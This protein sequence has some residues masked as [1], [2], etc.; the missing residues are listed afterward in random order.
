MERTLRFATFLAP[1]IYPVYDYIVE[2]VGRKVGC[3]AELVVGRSFDQFAMGEIDAGFIC[4][5][6]YVRLAAMDPSPI[7]VLAAPVLLGERYEDRPIYFSDVIVHRDS[8]CYTFADLRG[9]SWSFNDPDS[10]S[11]YGVTLHHL[12]SIG[13]TN[14]FFGKVIKAGFHQESIR[15]VRERWVDASAVD[16]QVLAVAMRD[17]PTLSDDLRVIG[18]LGPSSIQP[19]VASSHLPDALR[20]D[21]QAALLSMH[22]DPAARARLAEGLFRRFA[23]VTDTTYD[24]IRQ[25]LAA[26][27]AAGLTTLR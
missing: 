18:I 20:A 7:A 17:D 9:R 25:M 4:G 5:L 19:V 6:P 22:N 21:I 3:P 23:P 13:E 16:S 24:D 27:E 12:T 14:G 1:S 8:P 2:Y 10:H 11:G 26:A 15:L